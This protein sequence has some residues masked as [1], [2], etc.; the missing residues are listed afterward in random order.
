MAPT[1][2]PVPLSFPGPLARRL[3]I[4]GEV[5]P[6][7]IEVEVAPLDRIQADF[8]Q[9]SVPEGSRLHGVTIRE[10]RLPKFTVISV[11]LRDGEPIV[12]QPGDRLCERDELMV[13][14]PSARRAEA[15]ERFRS[16]GRSGRLARWLH[17]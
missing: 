4:A 12:P 16:I 14:V 2:G 10:L 5:D 15:E 8:M 1:P 3:G 9:V 17:P 7:D 11:I 13:V 6:T